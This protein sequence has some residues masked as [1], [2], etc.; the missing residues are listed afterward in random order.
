MNPKQRVGMRS[1][2]VIV[3]FKRSQNP[4]SSYGLQN[5]NQLSFATINFCSNAEDQGSGDASSLLAY[6]FHQSFL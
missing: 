1:S 3:G 5:E 6:M 2:F 4:S